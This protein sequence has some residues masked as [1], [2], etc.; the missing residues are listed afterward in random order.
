[1]IFIL[2]LEP[3]QARRRDKFGSKTENRKLRYIVNV[4][5]LFVVVVALV[6]VSHLKKRRWG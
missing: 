3:F 2:N 5:M 1:M 6:V 4:F